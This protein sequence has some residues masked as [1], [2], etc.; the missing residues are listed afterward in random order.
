MDTRTPAKLATDTL[1]PEEERA[2]DILLCQQQDEDAIATWID[3]L[4]PAWAKVLD[5]LADP[6]DD[7]RNRK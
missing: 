3:D 4:S 1:S 6:E 7:G 5:I 2:L